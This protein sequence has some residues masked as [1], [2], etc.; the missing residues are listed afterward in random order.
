LRK[1]VSHHCRDQVPEELRR[2]IA[3]LIDHEAH[4]A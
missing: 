1:L 2:R 4:Q 3:K